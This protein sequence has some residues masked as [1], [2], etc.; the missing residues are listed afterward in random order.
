MV[1]RTSRKGRSFTGAWQYYAHDKR[2]TA[3]KEQAEAVRS[4]E[5]VGFI[6][7]ENLAGIEDDRAAIGL[8][9]DTAR[10]SR[11]CEKPV[12][13]FSLAWHPEETPDKAH[14]IDMGREAL[15]SLIHI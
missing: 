11:R 13:A 7:I 1:P 2:T 15:L 6:H 3:Q 12:Y 14:M 9:I 8:M 10:Q 5:R 4:R